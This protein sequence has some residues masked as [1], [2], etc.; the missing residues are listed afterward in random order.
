MSE[1]TGAVAK[2][3]IQQ[4]EEQ[5]LNQMQQFRLQQL[6]EQ[7]Q[8]RL[9]TQAQYNEYMRQMQMREMI[10]QRQVQQQQAIAQLG[11]E[12]GKAAIRPAGT[13]AGG[14]TALTMGFAS[15]PIFGPLYFTAKLVKKLI[16]K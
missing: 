1:G 15:N 14:S 16:K 11:S 2:E 6:Q 12:A 13:T 7:L 4:Q 8:S 10:R 5:Q 3:T 9:I